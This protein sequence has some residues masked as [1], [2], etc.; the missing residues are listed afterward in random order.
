MPHDF[1]AECTALA[2]QPFPQLELCVV[3]LFCSLKTARLIQTHQVIVQS[4]LFFFLPK[5]QALMLY[6]VANQILERHLKTQEAKE[7][8]FPSQIV[9]SLPASYI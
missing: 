8:L 6:S 1:L 2:Y 4:L 7:I 5:I 9:C 3:F